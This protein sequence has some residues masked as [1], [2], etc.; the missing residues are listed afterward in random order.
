[1]QGEAGL[2]A[3]FRR[4]PDP[5]ST[6]HG[7]VLKRTAYCEYQCEYKGFHHRVVSCFHQ[8]FGYPSPSSVAPFVSPARAR[9]TP[10]PFKVSLAHALS[11][12]AKSMHPNPGRCAP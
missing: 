5:S 4:Y 1:M 11:V 2:G 6:E 9:V 7:E 12:H 8:L 10:V 3:R